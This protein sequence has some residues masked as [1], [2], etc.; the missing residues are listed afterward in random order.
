MGGGGVL[1]AWPGRRSSPP[2]PPPRSLRHWGPHCGA[3]IPLPLGLRCCSRCTLCSHS[4]FSQRP[5]PQEE[6]W[7]R[8]DLHLLPPSLGSR[9]TEQG[10]LVLP[11]D[12]GLHL[13]SHRPTCPGRGGASP[14][15]PPPAPPPL[16]HAVLPVPVQPP[17]RR[18]HALVAALGVDAALVTVPIAYAAFV[19]VWKQRL[20]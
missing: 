18:A 16:T 10:I 9:K 11:V 2:P 3:D 19:H 4:C 8:Q 7:G 14:V 20:E 6:L 5:L 12:H 13:R 1:G 17:A 15:P